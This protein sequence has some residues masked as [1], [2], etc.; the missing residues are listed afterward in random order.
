M[1]GPGPR[2]GAAVLAFFVPLSIP[3][4][5]AE[6]NQAPH[7]PNER[8]RVLTLAAAIDEG[9]AFDPRVAADAEGLRQAAA[10]VRTASLPP[11][12]L[13]SVSGTLIPFGSAFTAER[14]GGP[15]QLDF[16]LSYPLDWILFG[17]RG[18][19]V[20]S[21]ESGLEQARAAHN[22]FVRQRRSEIAAA[23][24]DV[25]EARDLVELARQETSDLDRIRTIAQ[26]RV[27]AGGAAAVEVDRTA[28]AALEARRELRRREAAVRLARATLAASLGRTGADAEFDVEG[29]LEAGTPPPLPDLATLV[30]A[31]EQA[32]PDI[33]ARRRAVAR[34]SAELRLARRGAW[35]ELTSRAGYS[36]QYQESLGFPD[37]SSWGL[38]LDLTIPLFDRNQGGIAR[39][40]SAES[41]R[42]LELRAALLALRP[43]I[44]QAAS[45]YSVAR[46]AALAEDRAQLEAAQRVRE[47]VQKAYEIG[48]RPL[49][50]VLDAQRVYREATR[51]S[52]SG[53]AALLRALHRLNAAVGR[54]VVP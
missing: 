13:L 49:L 36:H 23:F 17:K 26:D 43:E 39:A 53:R 4:A 7:P 47:R 51:Q 42:Q 11:N 41:Q 28:V 32:R 52:T 35:P 16:E 38:G 22:D 44:E 18:A 40:A 2:L 25:L 15:T 14:Q 54:D 33:L 34:A 5:R 12:P 37:A 50:E 48:G 20:G 3:L 45:E 10:D 29:D 30:S 31:A 9:L 46:E 27:A 21:A 24:I 6:E 8:L 19:A 1:T